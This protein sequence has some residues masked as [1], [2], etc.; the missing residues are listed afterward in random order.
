MKKRRCLGRSVRFG[1][2]KMIENFVLSL[3]EFVL[4]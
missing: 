1:S 4:S 3:I 2:Y